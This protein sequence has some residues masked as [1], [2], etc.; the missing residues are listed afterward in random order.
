MTDA[1]Q[2]ASARVDI[3]FL[4]IALNHLN[5]IRLISN[6]V[7]NDLNLEIAQMVLRQLYDRIEVRL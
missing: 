6:P 2:Q 3:H 1:L 7:V 5:Q 4:D